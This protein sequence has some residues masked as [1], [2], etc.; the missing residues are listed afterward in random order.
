MQLTATVEIDRKRDR[1]WLRINKKDSD[2]RHLIYDNG[3]EKIHATKVTVRGSSVSFRIWWKSRKSTPYLQAL[4][5]NGW[6]FDEAYYEIQRITNLP[7][8][9]PSRNPDV[10]NFNV[11]TVDGQHT[12]VPLKQ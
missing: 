5:K 11:H 2:N 3:P 7:M 1:Y 8:N 9:N 6:S 10:V 12:L 4:C